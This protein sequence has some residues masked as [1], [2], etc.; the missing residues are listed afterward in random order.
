MDKCFRGTEEFIAIYIDDILVFSESEADHEQHLKITLRICQENGLILSPTRMKIAVPEIEFLRAI[1]GKSKIKL[2]PHIIKKIC[3]FDEEKLKTK[4]GLRSF[5]GILNYARNY[6]PRLSLLLGPLY[7]KTNPHGDK[8]LKPSDYELVKRIKKEVQSLPDLQI[9]P[10]DA[11]IIIETD[12]CMEGWGGVCKWKKK[13]ED[14]KQQEKVCAYASGKFKVIQSTI[15][16][17]INACINSLE[18]LKICYLDKKEVTLRTDCQ[19]IISF[20]NKTNS[21]KAS[22]VRWLKFADIITGTW[23][24]INIEHI[25]GKQNVLADSL[26]RLINFFFAECTEQNKEIL[27]KSL[28][29]I[30]EILEED[31]LLKNEKDGSEQITQISRHCLEYLMEHL[32]SPNQ[33]HYIETIKSRPTELQSPLMNLEYTVTLQDKL[34]DK[35][36]AKSLKLCEVSKQ[37]WTPKPKSV[38]QSPAKITTGETIG[39]KSVSKIN[40]PEACLLNLRPYATS[41]AE[42][43]YKTQQMFKTQ[44][45]NLEA[46]ATNDVHI[47]EAYAKDN[48]Y[49]YSQNNYQEKNKWFHLCDDDKWCFE[50]GGPHTAHILQSRL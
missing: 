24:K 27:A 46:D 5:L 32:N 14:P 38:L 11:Y 15:D 13:N 20:Y 3:D 12:G 16:A 29:M 21:N 1:I 19:A 18:K 25:N 23:V 2:Q 39:R 37:F 31:A 36:L 17:E 44:A 33:E 7:E 40:R 26:S 43:R 35:P 49:N 6:I 41:W 10:E 8:R 45:R 30:E 48:K 50:P 34:N 4:A 47:L 42:S 9:P 28:T 22:R